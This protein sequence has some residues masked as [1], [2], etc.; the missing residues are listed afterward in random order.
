MEPQLRLLVAAGGTGGHFFPAVA[1]I[2]EA[3][4]L[5]KG[6]RVCFLGRADRIE[7]RLAPAL[8]YEFFPLSVSGFAGWNRWQS[9]RAMVQ[10]VSSS[11]RL[12]RF[13]RRFRP[14]VVLTTGAYL[15]IP[16]GVVA[17]WYGIPLVV[18]ELNVVPGRAVR[19]LAPWATV[20][21]TAY[22]RTAYF[23]PPSGRARLQWVGAP[24]RQE[25]FTVPSSAEARRQL[26]LEPDRATVAIL[27]GSLGAAR[28][29]TVARQLLPFVEQGRF[30]LIWQY[31]H[32]C[33]PPE[34][35]PRCGVLARP[36]FEEPALLLAAADCVVARA[37]GM[38]IAELCAV[39]RAAILVPYPAATDQHQ[40]ANARWMEEMGAAVC[41]ADERAEI[42]V[43]PMVERLLGEETTRE[44]MAMAARRLGRP[45]AASRLAL[46]LWSHRK[47]W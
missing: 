34:G 21:A 14:H 18:L 39:G 8:G 29:N 7:G 2:Q 38:T 19:L 3:E 11:V 24:V 40:W 43:P 45:E 30:Q 42:E 4:R 37:G 41:I 10:M 27:G 32:R 31:G 16:T 33:P 35:L 25:F 9:Y 28:L 5:G 23:L 46:L 13:V 15:A 26:G 36:F 22:E 12:A 20:V 17:R 6:L 1:V 47:E 44:Q